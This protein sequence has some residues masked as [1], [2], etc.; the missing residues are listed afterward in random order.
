MPPPAAPGPAAHENPAAQ[1]LPAV[2]LLPGHQS[3]QAE[4]TA[5]R[6]LAGSVWDRQAA[7]ATRA[8]TRM[9]ALRGHD[10]EATRADLVALLLYLRM[11]DGPLGHGELDRCLR[12]GDPRLL[13][14]A[15]CVASALRRMPSF[16]GPVL[17]GAGP[18]G[19]GKP[20][21]PA[22]GTV[23]R[24]P[25]PVS[26]LPGD[27]RG[28]SP[29]SARYAIWSVTG[30]RVRQLSDGTGPTARHDEVV[31]APGTAFRVL[32]V[33]AGGPSPLLLL[34]ELPAGSAA[35]PAGHAQPDDRDRA[36]LARL[37]E[38]LRQRPSGA[39][40]FDWPGRC[41]GPVGSSGQ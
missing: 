9:P 35:A 6:A 4:R 28:P 13:P 34:R 2:P 33:R 41:A 37:D 27:G 3:T 16:R 17:R 24:D 11:P 22:P 20:P 7:A 32:D 15:A 23:L 12:A 8:F 30:R 18:S 1:P 31:F 36:V 26:A 14:Y 19:T 25:A 21:A 10:Q 5:F 38:A 40:A 39:A 29:A